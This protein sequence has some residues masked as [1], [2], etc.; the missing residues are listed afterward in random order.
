MIKKWYDITVSEYKLMELTGKVDHYKKWYN[1]LPTFMFY[2]QI[3]KQASILLDFIH[4]N[5][6]S[7]LEESIKMQ[8]IKYLAKLQIE[9]NRLQAVEQLIE[10]QLRNNAHLLVIKS[11]IRSRKL[12]KIVD[13]PDVLRY[14]IKEAET[15]TGINMQTIKDIQ[16]FKSVVGHRTDKLSEFIRKQTDSKK[17]DTDKK[18]TLGSL[19]N[20]IMIYLELSPIGV[21]GMKAIDFM[22]FY[23]KAIAKYN[24][25][26]ELIEENKKL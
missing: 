6:N 1:L 5:R 4:D 12:R 25:E 19:I 16:S 22:D 20:G 7:E 9:V 15:L 18:E 23:K 8:E 10:I 17:P 3:K 13:M 14:A 11:R 24:K 2:S 21:D 26:K